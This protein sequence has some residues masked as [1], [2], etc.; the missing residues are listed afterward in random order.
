MKIAQYYGLGKG[1]DTEGPIFVPPMPTDEPDP[2][3]E[4]EWRR[5]KEQA[6]SQTPIKLQA[7]PE[8][9][10]SAIGAGLVLAL[11]AGALMLL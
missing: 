6:A 3:I 11:A 4:E 8:S 9:A 10:G 5:R 7:P 1:V 2:D